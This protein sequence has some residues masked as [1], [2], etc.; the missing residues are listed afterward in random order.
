VGRLLIVVVLSLS[1]FVSADHDHVPLVF[2][3]PHRRLLVIRGDMHERTP[4]E[5]PGWL[6]SDSSLPPDWIDKEGRLT[7]E[8]L[9]QLGFVVD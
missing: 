3:H 8:A 6:G 1:I 9:R 5:V 4:K 2:K 7:F